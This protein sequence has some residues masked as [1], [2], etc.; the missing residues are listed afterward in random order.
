LGIFE[1]E[2][3]DGEK[4]GIIERFNDGTVTYTLAEAKKVLATL[5]PKK[6]TLSDATLL[7][8]YAQP[9]KPIFGRI[10]LVKEV[11]LVSNEIFKDEVQDG[12]FVAYHFGPY[13]FTLGN[14]I[15][16]LELS[17]FL[18]RTGKKNSRLEHFKLTKKG[19]EVASQLWSKLSPNIQT[20]LQEKRKG[21]DQLGVDGILRLVYKDY[22]S[23]AKESYV[24]G[25]YR[26][27][28]WGK[29]TG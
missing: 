8:L 3:T 27:I 24:K 16:N 29:G 23:M 28:S 19:Q 25:R 7:I 2:M 15:S 18:D 4:E 10:L 26:S 11:F 9:D 21:W 17:G 6:F 22:K 12:N 1:K 5:Q 20:E 14:V 13:S